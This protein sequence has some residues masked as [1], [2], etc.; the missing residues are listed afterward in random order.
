MGLF[1]RALLAVYACFLTVVFLI[2]SAVMMGW[3]LPVLLFRGFFYP[4]RPNVLWALILVLIFAGVRLFWVSV[5]KPK[6]RHVVLAEGKPG[7]V[8]LSLQAIENLVEKVVSQINGVK[9]IKPRIFSVPQGI[10]IQIR[11]SVTPDVNI[12]EVSAEIQDRV[13]ERV[14]EVTGLSVGTVRVLIE[15]IAVKR[16][17][18]E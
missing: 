8:K 5:R 16:P 18:V 9:E 17:R 2:F 1:D 15:N 10:G 3:T 11:A 12:P 14:F 7:Q 4:G 6:G 13:K